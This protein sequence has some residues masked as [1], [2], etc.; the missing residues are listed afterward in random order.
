LIIISAIGGFLVKEIFS[1][2]KDQVMKESETIYSP[3]PDS[4]FGP[5]INPEKGYFVEEISDG[6]YWVTEG[7]YQVMF[8]TTGEGVIVIDAPPSIGENILNAIKDVSNEPITHVIYSHSHADHIAAAS[9][10]PDDAI[11]IAHEETVVNLANND[12]PYEFGAFLG[13]SP[14]PEP[15]VTF[16]DKYILEVGSQTL[17]LTYLG[18]NHN[19]GNI[20]I[21]A[22]KQKVLMLVDVI[23]PKWSPFKDLA[24]TTDVNE[25]IDSHDDVL[26]YEF[27]VLISGHLGRFGTREDVEIQQEYVLDMQANAAKALQ[28]VDFNT[29]AQEV[30]FGNIWLLIDKYLDAVAEECSDLTLEKWKNNLAAADVFTSSHCFKLVENLRIN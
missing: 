30:G 5:A 3:I 16:S 6:L 25:F 24:V 14:V 8:L 11:F 4:V 23:F 18:P 27:D 7:T 29:I 13:G 10:Y 17:E 12:D 20:F 22:P 26:S 9:M 21:Y 28:T 2:S 15:T 1:Y 19:P